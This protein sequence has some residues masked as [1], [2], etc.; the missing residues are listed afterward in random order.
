MGLIFKFKNVPKMI[1]EL[2]LDSHSIYR[3]E[4]LCMS[5][6][7]NLELGSSYQIECSKSFQFK[8]KAVDTNK[9][10]LFSD[11]VKWIKQGIIFTNIQL[12]N[13]CIY[14]VNPEFEIALFSITFKSE[15]EELKAKYFDV[16]GFYL[17]IQTYMYNFLDRAMTFHSIH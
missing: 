5:L 2:E 7:A 8:V 17:G 4:S 6:R 15:P 13:G 12:K 3:I 16:N 9:V 10:E 11:I 14:L 1:F